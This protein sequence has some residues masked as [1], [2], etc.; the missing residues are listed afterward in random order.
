MTTSQLTIDQALQM[1]AEAFNEPVDELPPERLRDTI[2]GWDSMGALM[3][4]AELDDRFGI[5]L[6]ADESRRMRSIGD[7]LEFLRAQKLLSD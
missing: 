4:I 6:P 7:A 3:L 5:E 1:L 2:V